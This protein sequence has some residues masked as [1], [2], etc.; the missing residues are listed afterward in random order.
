MSILPHHRHDIPASA[1]INVARAFGI[2]VE[3]QKIDTSIHCSQCIVH[4][5]DPADFD[6]SHFPH[7]SPLPAEEGIVTP[8]SSRTFAPISSEVINASPTSMPSTFARANL[9]TSLAVKI[10]L[11]ATTV[12][13]SGI[14]GRIRSVVSNETL[15][16]ARSRLFIPI[17]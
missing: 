17:K 10:P 15:K 3:T 1:N 12:M 7:L 4:S 9:S 14:I 11:S 13:S 2:E 8:L 16:V 5:L 6:F